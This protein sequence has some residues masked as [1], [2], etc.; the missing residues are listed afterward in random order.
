[1]VE[2]ERGLNQ[3]G[4]TRDENLKIEFRWAEG[5]Y[6]RLPEL[7]ADLVSRQVDVIVTGGGPPSALAAK[8]ATAT[9]PIVF[10]VSTDPVG[11]GL[12]RS[13]NRPGGNAT[14]INIIV[15]DLEAKRIGLL[16]ELVPAASKIAHL[17]NPNYPP[18]ATSLVEVREAA[19]RL[20]HEILLTHA[21]NPSEIDSAFASLAQARPA[22]LLVGADPVFNSR[23]SQIIDLVER[24]SIPTMYEVREFASSGGLMSYGTSLAEAYRLQGAYAGRILKGEKPSDLPIVRSSKFELIIN[25][26]TAKA[27]GLTIPPSL[28]ARA[29]EVIE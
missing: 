8:T 4:Y 16:H 20:G 26:K 6:Q 2:L 27:L 13:L 18:A 28:L 11:I 7:A 10:N 24:L 12:V 21:S 1:V 14:G 17:V 9:I 3:I 19:Q 25:L 22:A 23:R 15:S 5:Q 29:D